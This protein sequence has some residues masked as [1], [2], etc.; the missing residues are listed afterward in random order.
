MREQMEPTSGYDILYERCFRQLHEKLALLLATVLDTNANE[1][2]V[3][4]RVHSMVGQVFAFRVA[5]ETIRRRLGWESFEG[6]NAERVAAIIEENV[7]VLLRGLRS[8]R[9]N[10]PLSSRSKP[11]KKS[12][13]FSL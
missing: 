3:I 6:E 11:A 8:K 12:K 1:P 9:A 10:T 2:D 5:R 4:I 13:T 7:D